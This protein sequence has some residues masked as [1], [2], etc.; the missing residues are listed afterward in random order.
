MDNFSLAL[1][2][3]LGWGGWPIRFKCQPK[4][5]WFWVFGFLALGLWGLVPG[6]DNLELFDL[7]YTQVYLGLIVKGFI[8]T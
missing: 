6:L 4:A 3:G 7:I 5:P 8:S 2:I 1:P